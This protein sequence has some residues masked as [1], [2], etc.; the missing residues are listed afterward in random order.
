MAESVDPAIALADALQSGFAVQR[1]GHQRR[2]SRAVPADH[3][4]G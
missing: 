4:T 1:A 3:I 2:T